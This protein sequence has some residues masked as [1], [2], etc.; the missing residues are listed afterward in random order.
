MADKNIV[1]ASGRFSPDSRPLIRALPAATAARLVVVVTKPLD[2]SDKKARKETAFKSLFASPRCH[3]SPRYP[4]TYTYCT[5]RA[6]L[7]ALP[8]RV[9]CTAVY[10]HSRFLR[11]SLLSLTARSTPL[12]ITLAPVEE[13]TASMRALFAALAFAAALPAALAQGVS[14]TIAPM[15]SP[16]AGCSPDYNGEFNYFPANISRKRDLASV[17]SQHCRHV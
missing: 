3:F 16:P 9:Y 7:V 2:S 11:V 12:Y 5:A 14:S 8:P 4:C 10:T 13:E 1:V 6:S 15:Q 17:S